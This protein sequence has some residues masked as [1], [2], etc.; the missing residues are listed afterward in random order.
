ML[1]RTIRVLLGVV[2]ACV[3]FDA[4]AETFHGNQACRAESKNDSDTLQEAL[5]VN[6]QPYRIRYNRKAGSAAITS[7]D[8]KFIFRI[9]PGYD[10][11][12][13]GSERLIAFL[14]ERLQ[15]FKTN[16]VLIYVSAIRSSGGNGM[17]QCG[18][19]SEI[20]LNFLDISGNVLKL[21][22]SI[23]IGSCTESI[24]LG[25]QEIMEGKVG[26]ITVVDNKLTLHFLIYKNVDGEPVTVVTPDYKLE[27]GKTQTNPDVPAL[28]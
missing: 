16:N 3:M 14:P 28:Q 21:K 23:L 19:G 7:G 17:G 22:S 6:G 20:H 24:E 15:V 12:L 9:P 5:C 25:R 11:A 4:S 26:D 10:P 13:V 2:M 8:R 27:F 18:A 1:A